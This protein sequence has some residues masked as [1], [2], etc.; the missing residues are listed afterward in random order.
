MSSASDYV[1][2]H[3]DGFRDNL[4][5]PDA[6]TAT[7]TTSLGFTIEVSL[8]CPARPLLPTM[9]FVSILGSEELPRILRAAEDLILFRLPLYPLEELALRNEHDYFIY[10]LGGGKGASLELLPRPPTNF[11]DEDV[12]LLRH[13]DGHY[14]VAALHATSECGVYELLRFDSVTKKWSTDEV[15]LVEPQD[16]FQRKIPRNSY[17]ILFHLTSTV[18]PIGGEGGTMGWVD[19]WR[20]VLLCDVLGLEPKL[21][22]VP[23]PLPTEFLDCNYGQGAELGC[24]KSL[25]GITFVNGPDMEPC[26]R[27]VH[28]EPTAVPIPPEDSDD[29]EAEFPEWAM[30]EWKITTLSNSK[31]TTSW[32]DWQIDCTIEASTTNISNKLMSKM[33]QSGLLSSSERAFQNLLVSFPALGMDGNIVYLQARVRFMDPKV[34]ILALDVSHNV[35]LDV[36]EFATERIRGAGVVHFPSNISRYIEPDARV[37]FPEDDDSLEVSKYEGTETRQLPC[38]VI[39][40]P[41]ERSV[42]D[43]GISS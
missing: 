12:G 26:L 31:M 43:A 33:I 4:F 21:R 24:P 40:F 41:W 18:I 19:L 2:L 13:G 7:S 38:L 37:F 28:L 3:G 5:H 27:F 10:R 30:H 42:N 1:L 29:E 8:S 34:F 11:R 23:V 39:G 16:S 6:T 32:N 35:L 15:P 22:G 20:G 9:L 14:T 36:V 17:R 25:R